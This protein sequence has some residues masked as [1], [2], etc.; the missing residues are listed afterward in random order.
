MP[1]PI[2]RPAASLVV[3]ALVCAVLADTL[4]RSTPWGINA[5]IVG[6]A[7]CAAALYAL[8]GAPFAVVVVVVLGAGCLSML[9]WRDAEALQA[10]GV[11]AFLAAMILLTASS[12]GAALTALRI[13]DGLA[14]TLESGLRAI[15][16]AGILFGRDLNWL[17][18][19]KAGARH[20]MRGIVT[21]L[22]LA[23][24]VI[25]VF[26]A[27]L[28]EAEPRFAARTDWL[29]AWNLS[30]LVSHMIVTA[31]LTWL[32]AGY[33]RGLAVGGAWIVPP[34]ADAMLPRLRTVQ[35]AIPLGTLAL[36]LL[37]FAGI[38]VEYLF[39][40]AET[41]L[42]TDGL[43]V[44]EYARRGFFE[45]VTVTAL[46][47]GLLLLVHA[48][49]EQRD[50]RT[51]RIAL[52]LSLLLITL[53]A[54]VM[55]SAIVRMQLY[56]QH[57]G[58]TE[59]RLYAMAFMVWVGI[60]LAWFGA[61]VL[62]GFATRFAYGAVVAGF[63]T[64][65]TIGLLNPHA[66]IVRTNVAHAAQGNPLDTQYLSRLSADAVPAIVEAWP[67]LDSQQRCDLWHGMLAHH[68]AAAPADWRSWNM[69]RRRA[70]S[71]ATIRAPDCSDFSSSRTFE[72]E[73][74]TL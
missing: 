17:Q 4:L 39:G 41:L 22:A 54:V 15:G 43:T 69:A 1:D 50:R 37:L 62:R 74:V 58:L 7:A 42:R 3:A 67:D 45:L 6:F 8:R 11:M 30:E 57:F 49:I 33:L 31:V 40:G 48:T 53:V 5:V 2:R 66:L 9:A 44:A 19:G 72:P 23:I 73:I 63:A 64:L 16:G 27:L 21:G 18:G 25:L 34:P 51:A 65:L 38:Q 56:V 13:R 70:G 55:V 14:A 20:D 59:D 47:L 71:A 35:L 24:P 28:R 60:S 68:A 61:T 52:L 10:W 32:A 29:L 26:G 46:V 12:A 36:M